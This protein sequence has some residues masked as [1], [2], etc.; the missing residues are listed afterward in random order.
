[1]ARRAKPKADEPPPYVCDACGAKG[2]KLWRPYQSFHV[3]LFCAWCATRDQNKPGK[4]DADGFWHDDEIEQ[5]CDQIGW[6]VP[7][8]PTDDGSFWGYTSVPMDRVAWWR[9]LPTYPGKPRDEAIQSGEG[10]GC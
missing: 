10:P 1:M 2:C 3:E 9:A 5:K 4:I 6:L 8:V 7:A